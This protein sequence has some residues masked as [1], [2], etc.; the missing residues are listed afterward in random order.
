MFH[1]TEK[2]KR[3][4]SVAYFILCEIPFANSIDYACSLCCNSRVKMELD[5]NSRLLTEEERSGLAKKVH[6]IAEKRRRKF[7]IKGLHPR[8]GETEME[9]VTISD[10]TPQVADAVSVLQSM[11]DNIPKPSCTGNSHFEP[12]DFMDN[13]DGVA[14]ETDEESGCHGQKTIEENMLREPVVTKSPQKIPSHDGVSDNMADSVDEA[15]TVDMDSENKEVEEK[16]Q[17]LLCA[18]CLTLADTM[19]E[20]YNHIVHTHSLVATFR[21]VVERLC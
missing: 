4:L 12:C 20:M 16:T 17:R 9:T 14:M 2:N 19:E 3:L 10:C 13:T 5:L 1:A 11:A 21:W 6:M 18:F 8:A 15:A 7:K